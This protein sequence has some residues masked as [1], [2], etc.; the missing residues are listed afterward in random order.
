MI[1]ASQNGWVMEESSDKTWSTG[2]GKGKPLQYSCLV[3]LMNSRKRQK[4]MT[5]KNGLPRSV[6]TQHATG[7]EWRN[8]TRKNEE[9]DPKWKQH[10]VVDVTGDGS[11]DQCY[12]EK[13]CIG[14]W[15]VKS[16]NQSKLEVVKQELARVNIDILGINELKCTGMGKFNSDDHYIYY[17]GQKSLRRNGVAI[18]VNKSLKW[19]TWVQSQKCQK[20]LSSFPRETIQYHSNLSIGPNQ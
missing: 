6:G 1:N 13:Y 17:C 20:D 12:K 16:M 11:K 14:T 19:S 4:D 2:E 8:N 3:N 15:N 9:T 18:I 5:L 10:S 7:E